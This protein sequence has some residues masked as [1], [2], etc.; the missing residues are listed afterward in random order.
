VATK[1]I[2]SSGGDYTTL[3]AWEAAQPGTLTE[4]ETAECR[5]FALADNVGFAGS[6]TT[7]AF[8]QRIYVPPAYR[9]DGRS[10]AVSGAGFRVSESGSNATLRPA[11]DYMRFEG[12][13]IEQSGTGSALSISALSAGSNDVRVEKCIVHDVKTGTSYTILASV[14]NLNLTLRN[15][16]IYG[17]QRSIDTRT[18]ASALIENCTFWRHAAQLGVVSD[19]ELTCKNTY[20][21]HTGA[22]AEDFFTGAAAPSGNNNASSD[23]SQATD[24]TAGVSSVAGSAVFTSVTSGSEDFSLLSGTNALV[25]AGATLGSVTDDIDG[26][27]RPQGSLY[28]IGAFER[29][30][31]GNVSVALTGSSA[32]SS[33]GTLA[34]ATD[35]ALTGSSAT[36]GQGDVVAEIGVVVALTGQEM[37][38]AVGSV[39]PSN[40]VALSGSEAT[41]S[42]GTMV[43]TP[44]FGLSGQEATTEQGSVTQSRTVPLTGEALASSQGTMG[45]VGDVT[46]A[47]TGQSMTVSLGVMGVIGAAQETYSGGFFELPRMKRVRSVEEERERLGIIPKKVKQIIKAVAAASVQEVK[48]DDQAER[49]LAQ[50]LAAQDIEAQARFAEFMRAERDRLLSRD[51]GIALR[52]KA[53]QEA[54]DE[55]ER[56]V[57]MLL[58]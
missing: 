50:R 26:T 11:N 40:T 43:A 5:D 25:E 9:H 41:A 47:L 8:Y 23:T 42:P 29:A 17:S 37:T 49:Q 44:T 48:T 54:D 24:Y 32:T 6:T 33:I 27:A 28:D 10:R 13:E 51:I 39:S 2:D 35:K 15:N 56:E 58:M 22:A 45:I 30:A 36:T 4:V 34:P 53:K 52:I 1:I 57:E 31:G 21:G 14:A 16:V 38:A 18:A 20:S 55:D 19:S 7:A 3:T 46:V 12:L